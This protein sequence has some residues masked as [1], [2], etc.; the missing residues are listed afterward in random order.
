MRFFTKK[1]YQI[2]L[3]QL[4]FLAVSLHGLVRS[5]GAAIACGLLS[6]GFLETIAGN[7]G[8]HRYFGHRS[9]TTSRSWHHVLTFL[10]HYIGVGSVISWVGQHR[11]H[12]LHSDTPDDVHSP[13]HTGIARILFGI[14]KVRIERSMVRDVIGDR[15][16][17][18]YHRNYFRM[19]AVIFSAL[20]LVDLLFGSWFLFSIYTLP[21]LMCLLS[22]YVLA[23]VPHL[24]GY[25]NYELADSSRNCWITNLY[26]LGEGWHNNHHAFPARLRQGEHWWE[27]DLPA[28]VIESIL[29]RDGA[30]EPVYQPPRQIKPAES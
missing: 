2:R 30:G 13:V 18:W 6:Y 19:H 29:Q 25:R 1:N 10:T 20:L 7:I 15:W 5:P 22:G 23:I 16:L 21:N 27:W 4:M 24:R 9:F 12:H 14:W 28:F 17:V 11:Y 8:L 3:L 26:T